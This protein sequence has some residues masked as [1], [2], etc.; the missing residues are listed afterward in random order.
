MKYEIMMHFCQIILIRPYN[1]IRL[2][3]RAL[4]TLKLGISLCSYS[5][6]IYNMSQTI[7]QIPPTQ[8]G[9]LDILYC[10]IT[11]M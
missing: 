4:Y 8:L 1:L 3:I 2:A 7:L 11:V 5:L 9:I 10:D 6:G